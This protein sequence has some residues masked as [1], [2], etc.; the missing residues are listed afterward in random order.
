MNALILPLLLSLPL[1]QD[2]GESPTKV[3][4]PS[5]LKPTLERAAELL[6]GMQEDY[7]K[8]DDDKTYLPIAK[9]QKEWPYQGVYR[10]RKDGRI[11]IPMGYR[12]GGTSITATALL[13]APGGDA[14]RKKAIER[15]LEFVLKALDD[16]EMEASG[17][18]TYDVRGWGHT[19][20]LEFLLKMRALKKV[21]SKQKKKVDKKITWLVETLLETEI[22]GSGGWNYSRSGSSS[23]RGR[24]NREPRP[25]PASPFMTAPTLMALYEAKAQGEEVDPAVI[26]RALDALESCRTKE[27]GYPYTTGGRND[28]MPGC[29]ARTP[30]TEVALALAGR[31]DVDRLRNSIEKFHEHWG[32]LEVRRAKKGTHIG[33]Y[34]V[35]PYYVMFGHRYVAMAIELLP[36][37]EREKHR[38]LVY[39]RL[40]EIKGVEK[41]GDNE[42]NAETFYNEPDPGTWND[43]V[44]PRSRSFGTA[45]AMMTLMQQSLPL[46]AEW[47]PE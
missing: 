36:E 37:E 5:N 46:P 22:P 19:Y 21:P 20:A 7:S 18:Y 44:F 30:V 41:G 13:D 17:N 27:N 45:C 25:S 15:G 31:G 1:L 34:G 3:E 14:E 47:D 35:A 28:E 10:I 24:R 29:I 12:I 43:R 9:G 38:T 16:E 40:F 39:Q 8:A 6:V 11:V 2:E 33:D 4:V 26:T 42:R 23:R 32:E